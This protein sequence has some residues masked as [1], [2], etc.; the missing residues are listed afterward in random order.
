MLADIIREEK[1]PS[2]LAWYPEGNAIFQ[3]DIATIHRSF[4][5]LLNQCSSSRPDSASQMG[6][7]VHHFFTVDFILVWKQEYQCTCLFKSTKENK[8]RK[9]YHNKKCIDID[10]EIYPKCLAA[11][12]F[13]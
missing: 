12:I 8:L 4:V 1:K 6:I 2:I 10:D 13:K 9:N 5:K 3:D 7:S 11:G